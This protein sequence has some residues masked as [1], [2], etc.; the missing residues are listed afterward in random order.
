MS[1]ERL[2]RREFLGVIAA[3]GL[4]LSLGN[5]C[6]N[7]DLADSSIPAASTAL[8]VS[9]TPTMTPTPSTTTISKGTLSFSAEGERLT[10]ASMSLF[11]DKSSQMFRAPV[12]SSETVPSDA[13]H[14]RGYTLW[15]SLV[16]MHALVEAEKVHPGQ[17]TKQ[18]AMVFD[19]LQQYYSTDLGAY[20]SWVHFPGNIDAYYDDNAWV[21]LVFAEASMACRATD[22]IRAAQYLDRAKSVMANYLVK[23][24]DTTGK[25]GGTHWGSDPAKPNTGD[26][27]T[28]STAGSTLAALVL[29]RAGA[30]TKFYT[31][32]GLTVLTWLTTHLQD[33]DGLI[34]DALTPPKWDVR[35]VKWTYNTGIPMRAYIEHYRLTKNPA[36]LAMA[37]KLARAAL[38]K[39]GAL[40]D[41]KVTDPDKRY[42]WDGIYFV[43]YLADGLLQV[44]QVTP[45]AKLAADARVAITRS[46]RYAY[47]HLRDT[48]GFYWRNMRLYTIGD[49]QLNDW[50]KMTE[51]TIAPDYDASERSQEPKYQ[52]LAVKDRPLVKTLLAN[53]AAARL[54]WLASR[55]P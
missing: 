18:I 33:T 45:D 17:Y 26:R 34:M 40:F 35:R 3:S 48:D 11:W 29:A 23:G 21:V 19:G 12:L 43:H 20:S 8:P 51:Q 38:N 16:G 41:S 13:L 39:D 44:S 4:S 36:S 42:F 32:W 22:P 54:F 14:D 53:G 50:E 6:K 28:S 52:S 49:A 55:V 2:N 15:P 10:Q 7:D 25:P 47:D 30:D 5:G 9:A 37:T 46:A 27:G 31:N 1:R 24:Y